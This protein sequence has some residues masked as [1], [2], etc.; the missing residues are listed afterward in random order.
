VTSP[1]S[2]GTVQIKPVS[3]PRRAAVLCLL[4]LSDDA[5]SSFHP[6]HLAPVVGRCSAIALSLGGALEFFGLRS[7]FFYLFQCEIKE[8]TIALIFP[9]SPPSGCVFISN[10]PL[11]SVGVLFFLCVASPRKYLF[12]W[13]HLLVAVALFMLCSGQNYA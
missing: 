12:L 11:L 5:T 4:Y 1:S 10:I 2:L 7:S 8:D 9:P 3:P 13:A 6:P